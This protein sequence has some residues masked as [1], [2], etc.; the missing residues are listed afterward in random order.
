MPFETGMEKYK[1]GYSRNGCNESMTLSFTFSL[2]LLRS[3]VQNVPLVQCREC[4][5]GEMP[6]ASGTFIAGLLGYRWEVTQWLFNQQSCPEE[7]EVCLC[8]SVASL[9]LM[10]EAV[11]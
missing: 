6:F 8:I 1:K 2:L 3:W 4:R 10:Q 5:H 7:S 11:V 9:L